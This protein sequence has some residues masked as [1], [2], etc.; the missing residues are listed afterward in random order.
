M[1]SVVQSRVARRCPGTGRSALVGG[2]SAQGCRARS[3]PEHRAA[4]PAQHL[5]APTGSWGNGSGGAGSSAAHALLRQPDGDGD[6]DGGGDD[7]QQDERH[8]HPLARVLLQP[9]GRHQV[10]GAR[11]HVLHALGHLQAARQGPGVTVPMLP[12]RA[13]AGAISREEAADKQ[14]GRDTAAGLLPT[15]TSKAELWAPQV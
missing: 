8:A 5:R 9:L 13:A 15:S 7:E 11:L 6:G 2:P 1:R 14:R 4:R 3:Q 10:G 12:E